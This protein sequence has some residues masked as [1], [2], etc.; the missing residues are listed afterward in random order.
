MP[1]L[2]APVFVTVLGIGAVSSYYSP[3]FCWLVVLLHFVG[4]AHLLP[5]RLSS[6]SVSWT[7]CPTRHNNDGE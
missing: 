3:A 7:V 1:S 6:H 4:A 5:Y 2:A